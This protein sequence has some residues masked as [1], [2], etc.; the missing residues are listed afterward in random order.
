MNIALWIVASLLAALFLVSGAAKV[1]QT[2]E[3][4]IAS[5]YQWAEDYS[6]S[7]VTFIGTAEVVG[8]IGLVLPA[9]LGMV[10]VLTP[11]AALGLTLLMVL[12][13]YAH[14]R[15]HEREHVAKPL[16]L[17]VLAAAVAMLRFGPYSF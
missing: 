10:E 6:P 3:K 2:R 13:A 15:R 5:G 9:G 17:A 16:T 12:A 8:A 7:Q 11:T 14:V 1:V 4:V